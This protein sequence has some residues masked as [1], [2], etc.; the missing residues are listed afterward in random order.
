MTAA[1]DSSVLVPAL[2]G[3]HPFH[4]AAS[5]VLDRVSALPAH[6]LLETYGTL[7]RLPGEDRVPASVAASML[8]TLGIGVVTLPGALFLPLLG[9]LAARGLIGGAVHDGLVAAT[10]KHHDLTLVT[11]DR[12]ARRTYEAVGVRVEMVEG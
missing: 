12:R 3:G 6:V 4:A 8:E 7:T 1:C 2:S 11:R 10:A 5:P 9:S